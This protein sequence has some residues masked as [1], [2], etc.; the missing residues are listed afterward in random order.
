MAGSQTLYNR[1]GSGNNRF[2]PAIRSGHG[3]SF[4]LFPLVFFRK[5]LFDPMRLLRS[6]PPIR[7]RGLVSNDELLPQPSHRTTPISWRPVL[8]SRPLTR[9]YGDCPHL[10]TFSSLAPRRSHKPQTGFAPVGARQKA[11]GLPRGNTRW[12]KMPAANRNRSRPGVMP[13]PRP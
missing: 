4:P 1:L 12:L 6:D 13:P 5:D 9:L 11:D 2:S 7:E 3:V 10:L 8:F